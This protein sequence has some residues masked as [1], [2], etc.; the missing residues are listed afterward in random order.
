MI[1][2]AETI[3]KEVFGFEAFRPLQAEIIAHILAGGDAL[4]VMPTGGGKSLCFQIPALIFDRLTV[5]VSPLIA[6]MQDQ[7][8]ALRENGVPAVVLNSMLPG[9]QYR[10]NVEAIQ[11]GRAKLLYIAPESLLKPA[12]LDL[13]T[14]VGVACLAVDEAHCISAWGH[15]FRPEYRQL[16]TLREQFRHIPFVALTATA[17]PRV[18]ADIQQ[19]LLFSNSRTFI[20]SFDRPNL[21]LQVWEKQSPLEQIQQFIRR[22]P[23]RSGIIYCL[24]RQQVE[25]VARQLADQGL[26]IRPYHAGLPESERQDNQERFIRDDIQ[27]IA[28]TIAFGM[29]IDKPDV[30]FV[31]HHDL[32]HSLEH[33]YQEIGRAGRDGLRSEC[34]L[35]LSYVDVRKI[36]YFIKKKSDQEQPVARRALDA[37]LRF[38]ESVECRRIP[39]LAHFGETITSTTCEMC[40]RCLAQNQDVVDLTIPAQK[41]LSC[42]VRTSERF[43]IHHTINV[44][45]GSG[46]QKVLKFNHHKLSTYNIGTE[47]SQKQW[48]QI[49]R[50]LLAG[51]YLHQDL[52]HGS[53]AVTPRGWE[54]LRR[55]VT[56]QGRLESDSDPPPEAGQPAPPY[57]RALFDH[58]RKV[59]KTLADD[60]GIAPYVIFADRTL[61]EMATFFPDTPERLAA[62]HGVG[63]YKLEA[64]GNRFL[65]ALQAYCRPRGLAPASPPQRQKTATKPT[66]S[67]RCRIVGQGLAAGQDIPQLMER[68][69][70][71]EGTIL[72][73]LH[74]YL[75]SGQALPSEPLYRRS[76]LPDPEKQRVCKAFEKLGADFLKPVYDELEQAVSYDELHRLRLYYLSRQNPT[77]T[78]SNPLS[79]SGRPPS[80]SDA[81]LPAETRIVCLANSRK[82]S[83]YCFAGKVLPEKRPGLSA[84]A[85]AGPW[86]RPVGS[87]DTGE[88]A[89]TQMTLA[90]GSL[91][92]LLD[93]IDIP[94]GP[95]L[96]RE[97]QSENHALRPVPWRRTGRLPQDHLSHLCD[98]PE[99]LWENGW[100]SLSGQNDRLPEETARR[101]HQTSL[102]L[103]QPQH[104]TVIVETGAQLLK[105]VRAAFVYQG[106]SY[107]FMVTDPEIERRFMMQ[108]S[109]EYPITDPQACLTISLGEPFQGFCYKLVAAI[110]ADYTALTPNS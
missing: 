105:Q 61:M 97:Y 108:P 34:L 63:Q 82:Y 46:A 4:V 42:V 2:Q 83:G 109:G 6:L 71:T 36:T 77:R 30:R 87:S 89:L 44:L 10:R 91:P 15:D 51:G 33:Y 5:V 106:Q 29:G 104:L 31:I 14:S 57:N 23:D 78:I 38:A 110:L 53:L 88:L 19:S 12:V 70:V 98:Q 40:D 56:F 75:R 93:I 102:Y 9:A 76:T 18:Q 85:D 48:E 103:I 45:R 41:F 66:V 7:V 95:G 47:Y 96:P 55:Q 67:E 90:D 27:I 37:L 60:A 21:F 39:L 68:L 72:K 49:A 24:T 22:F 86:V 84:I 79:H 101:R 50:Q 74:D 35:L 20:G 94:L 64:Y 92:R 80:E 100:A 81:P 99:G 43:G 58:L 11:Q 28:A 59:R 73:H 65:E 32:P 62:I 17:T 107:R 52:S 3:L 69:G 13:L 1:R 16:A 54:V 8:T 26:R 25:D